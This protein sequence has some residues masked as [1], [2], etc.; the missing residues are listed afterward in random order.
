M[1]FNPP[2]WIAGHGAH[3]AQLPS[4]MCRSHALMLQNSSRNCPPFFAQQFPDRVQITMIVYKAAS[5]SIREIR[6]EQCL[7][8]GQCVWHEPRTWSQKNMN[9]LCI[10][11]WQADQGLAHLPTTITAFVRTP[12]VRGISGIRET[13]T[14]LRTDNI[15]YLTALA[16]ENRK[17]LSKRRLSA[18]IDRHLA[19]QVM[20]A[21]PTTSKGESLPVKIEDV[22]EIYRLLLPSQSMIR[23]N[24]AK[25]HSWKRKIQLSRRQTCSLLRSYFLEYVCLRYYS[26]SHDYSNARCKRPILPRFSPPPPTTPGTKGDCSVYRGPVAGSDHDGPLI[27]TMHAEQAVR[28]IESCCHTCQNTEDCYGFAVHPTPLGS[29]CYFHGPGSVVSSTN[30][31]VAVYALQ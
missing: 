22:S 11:V 31:F 15:D 19:S 6:H 14:A 12:L 5:T 3:D 27:L 4:E 18:H 24:D 20:L 21:F 17:P 28:G 26:Y 2:A 1:G 10:D 23:L 30:R 16:I 25:S 8:S 9:A 7:R 29:M 13:S